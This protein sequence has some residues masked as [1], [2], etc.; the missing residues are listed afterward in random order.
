LHVAALQTVDAAG[1]DR[2]MP[3]TGTAVASQLRQRTN[4]RFASKQIH[5]TAASLAF[6]D[7]VLTSGATFGRLPLQM[8]RHSRFA[9]R[10]GGADATPDPQND[11]A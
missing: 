6:S 9:S 10:D 1:L 3:A 4:T 11:T 7:H 5:R 8:I 2:D